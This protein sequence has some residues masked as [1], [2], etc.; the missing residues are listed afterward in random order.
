MRYPEPILTT[1]AAGDGVR[2]TARYESPET[3][4]MMESLRRLSSGAIGLCFVLAGFAIHGRTFNDWLSGQAILSAALIVITSFFVAQLLARALHQRRFF[5]RA[6]TDAHLELILTLRSV[7]HAE[8]SY[9]RTTVLRFTA[10]QHRQGRIEERSE[11]VKERL[12]ST[13][14]R[15]AWQ[16]WLQSGEEFILL[17][18]VSD[19]QGAQA[20]V[21]RLQVEDEKIARFG[22]RDND[23]GSFG[24]RQSPS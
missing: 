16:V 4:R 2:V 13:S 17:A 1:E 19:E 12:L 18:D 8:K 11:R 23:Q 24:Q 14:Y 3:A 22:N 15:E 21:R 7:T 20:I 9:D 5:L 10:A 6:L